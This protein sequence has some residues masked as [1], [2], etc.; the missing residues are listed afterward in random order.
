MHLVSSLGDAILYATWLVKN[1]HTTFSRS[2][3]PYCF[4][5]LSTRTRCKAV[6]AHHNVSKGFRKKNVTIFTLLYLCSFPDVGVESIIEMSWKCLEVINCLLVLVANTV[7]LER[8]LLAER[9]GCLTWIPLE[10]AWG[11][12]G[13][14]LTLRNW[15][16][17]KNYYFI[18]N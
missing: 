15:V 16:F 3:S 4:L 2:V 11:C 13:S 18:T 6:L 10:L 7:C 1:S 8:C 14:N 17:D 9:C 12:G 5:G